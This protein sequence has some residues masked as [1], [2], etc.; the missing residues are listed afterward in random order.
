MGKFAALKATKTE[1]KE[2]VRS[3]LLFYIYSCIF[4]EAIPYICRYI[5]YMYVVVKGRS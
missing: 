4:F 2:C 5:S 1:E 3:F